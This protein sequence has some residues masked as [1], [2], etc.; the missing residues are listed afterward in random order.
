MMY[1]RH[2]PLATDMVI[3]FMGSGRLSLAVSLSDGAHN[4]A[5]F[6]GM[7]RLALKVLRPRRSVRAQLLNLAGA[8][9]A[10]V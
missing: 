1:F 9:I 3:V 10:V 8:A 4:G 2:M 6:G 5:C 7:P